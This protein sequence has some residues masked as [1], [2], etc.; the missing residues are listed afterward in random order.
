MQKAME[1][2]CPYPPHLS[3]EA[4]DQ[5]EA[6]LSRGHFG[7]A[8]LNLSQHLDEPFVRKTLVEAGIDPDRLLQWLNQWTNREIRRQLYR[9]RTEQPCNR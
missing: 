9:L 3:R 4:R 8:A 6:N 1:G 2:S 7:K 5:I